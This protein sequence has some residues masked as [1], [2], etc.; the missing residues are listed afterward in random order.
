[1]SC[2]S[3]CDARQHRLTELTIAEARRGATIWSV[4]ENVVGDHAVSF[5]ACV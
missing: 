2:V 4:L 5:P 1:M 3:G